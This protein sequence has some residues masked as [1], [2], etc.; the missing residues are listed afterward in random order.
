MPNSIRLVVVF[1]EWNDD[2]TK[3]VATIAIVL[4]KLGI[5]AVFGIVLGLERE[6]KHKPLG[7]KTC[8]VISVTSCLLTIVSI[9]TATHTN[10][11]AASS[12]RAD[13]M[14]LAAQIVSGIGF[15][16][17]GVIMRRSNEMISGLTT[18]AI[19]WAASGLGIATGAGYYWQATAGV[20]LIFVSVEVIPAILRK[21]GPKALREKEVQINIHVA[22]AKDVQ[23]ALDALRLLGVS[24]DNVKI[25]GRQDTHEIELLCM[26]PVDGSQI[27]ELYERI[28]N[29][30][31]IRG[32][33]IELM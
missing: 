31:V 11:T 4:M 32:V 3:G 6:I 24:I 12:M 25:D 8:L 15:L 30:D 1:Y 26:A 20:I 33:R 27:P 17:A 13:P 14:R 9:E 2:Q 21:L 7:L 28:H 29:V 10:L 23:V 16:G 5:A 19:V 18:A 22:Q